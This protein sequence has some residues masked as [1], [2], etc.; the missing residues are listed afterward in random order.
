M[1]TQALA[2]LALISLVV[3]GVAQAAGNSVTNA[4]L[5]S[6]SSTTTKTTK[7]TF[8]STTKKLTSL[9]KTITK[10][11]AS[12]TDKSLVDLKNKSLDK[13]LTL[14]IKRG[15][16]KMGMKPKDVAK[17]KPEHITK[18]AK[19][20]GVPMTGDG[21]ASKMKLTNRLE[22]A[23]NF[24]SD[25]KDKVKKVQDVKKKIKKVKKLMATLAK[26][27]KKIGL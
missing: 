21:V 17:V 14:L 4:I 25:V 10:G 11:H 16:K 18:A 15:A 19:L 2:L 5:G 13:D 24:E 20:M 3:P 6:S 8:G 27:R 22:T 23:I 7:T 9:D 26:Y 12:L 1:K